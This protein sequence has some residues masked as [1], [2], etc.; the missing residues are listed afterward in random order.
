MDFLNSIIKI[1]L[2]SRKTKSERLNNK[3]D[4]IKFMLWGNL[5]EVNNNYIEQ[6]NKK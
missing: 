5:S 6:I 3:E 2:F 4:M 1:F